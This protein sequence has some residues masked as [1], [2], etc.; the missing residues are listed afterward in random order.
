M[1][2]KKIVILLLSLTVLSI[3]TGAVLNRIVVSANGGM[4]TIRNTE[5]VGRWIAISQATR[6]IFL[7]DIIRIGWYDLSVGD[8]FIITGIAISMITVW[9]AMPK[10]RKFLPLLIAN[11]IGI[12]M[13]RSLPDSI[14]STLLFTIAAVVTVLVM[15][16]KE[17]ELSV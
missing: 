3:T 1:K 15:Y 12:F 16:F 8:L 4:P 17:R 6:F 9:I 14:I 5:A 10:T 11:V 7:S 2:H 13:S